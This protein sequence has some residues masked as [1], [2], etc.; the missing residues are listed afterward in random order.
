MGLK[1]AMSVLLVLFVSASELQP[2]ALTCYGQDRQEQDWHLQWSTSDRLPEPRADYAAGILD[3]KL[4]IAGGTYWDGVP[5]HWTR[6]RYS[7]STHGFDPI[8]KKWM[9]LPD[10]PTALAFAASAVV[11]NTLLV[12]GGYTGTQ[13]SR[14]IFA[15][16]STHG[17]YEWTRKGHMEVDRLF[18]STVGI[19]KTVY[20]IGG[21]SKFE[22]YDTQGTCCTT[23]SVTR[24]VFAYR[25]D[26]RNE[27]DAWRE[28]GLYP[29]T[30]KWM[31]AVIADG[32]AVW[33]FG[34]LSQIR[35]ADAISMSPEVLKFDTSNRTWTKAAGLPENL[36][37]AQPLTAAKVKGEIVL[38]TGQKSAWRFNPVMEKY[39]ETT[40]MP[41]GVEVD[42]FFSLNHE[43]IGAGGE[44]Q[45]E[46][47]GRRSAATFIAAVETGRPSQPNK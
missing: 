27:S 18:A 36:N 46:G 33:M 34:G 17:R 6:K 5:G 16:R 15:L 40:P 44:A 26:A 41:E 21:S 35:A 13:V 2:T 29:G 28:L 38:F 4:I 11:E 8:S 43:I 1:K 19:G 7:A 3:G 10:L 32:N 31:P 47:P 45:Q 22:P 37:Q 25:T 14:D 23:N 39:R 42:H 9:R 20:L 30:A 12:F 24:T